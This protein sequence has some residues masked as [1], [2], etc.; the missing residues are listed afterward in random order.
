M[1]SVGLINLGCARNLVDSQG[2]LGRLK[3]KGYAIVD[4]K[5]ADIAVLNTCGFIEEAKKES[6]DAILD[7]VDLKKKGKIKKIIVS[8][9]LA[10]RYGKELASELTDIDAIVGVPRF[11][12][13]GVR[14]QVYLTPQHFAYLK[15]C[16]SCYNQCHFCTIPS[17][18]G[19]FSSRTLDSILAEVKLLDQRGVKELNIIGQDITA[20]GIDLYHE[21]RLVPLLKEIIKVTHNI[22]WIRLLYT[23]PAH[24]SDELI[25]IIAQE[26]KI[27]NYIDIPLQHIS[28]SVLSR[29]NRHI[30]ARQTKELIEK[31]RTRIPKASIRTTFIV[32]L[33]GETEEDFEELVA[34]TR[35]MHFEKV[36]IFTYSREEET[37]AYNMPHQ[38]PEEIKKERQEL[39]MQEQ[40]KISRVIQQKYVGR[41]LNVLIDKKQQGQKD[42][43]LGRT[44]YDAPD[45][46]GLIYVHS[47]KK[48][49]YGDFIDVSVTDSLE[50]DLRGD[51]R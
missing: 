37:P 47:K 21:K 23:F 48:L 32:G 19:K 7:L 34:F 22:E 40:Q 45:V 16:E 9:C 27:C 33:P 3:Q 29:M 14:T 12:T 49:H 30:T 28:D 36:G 41:T 5:K 24:V 39:L 38:V 17:I 44:E 13:T 6:I 8:G 18:K 15:I 35:E 43:Y 1:K 46:D 20:Y 51:V 31:I 50:Y 42:I 2:V 25:D 4:I 10:Q 26:N 11:N